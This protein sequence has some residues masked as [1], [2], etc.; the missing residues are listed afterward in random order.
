MVGLRCC[1]RRSERSCSGSTVRSGRCLG[2]LCKFVLS[3][4]T[5][6]RRRTLSCG[7]FSS[8]RAVGVSAV[9]AAGL[10]ELCKQHLC[11]SHTS[12]STLQLN[13]QCLDKGF[14]LGLYLFEL[15]GF[16]LRLCL[17]LLRL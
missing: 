12:A 16:C 11:N 8:C 4:H 7:L 6:Y 15:E 17:A 1:S 10:Q 5:R 2:L 13:L 9:G 3:A 14:V